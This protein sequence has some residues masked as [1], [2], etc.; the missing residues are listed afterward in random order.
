ML[1]KR[2][3]CGAL[4]EARPGQSSLS[5]GALRYRAWAQSWS[6]AALAVNDSSRTKLWEKTDSKPVNCILWWLWTGAV[7]LLYTT[8]IKQHTQRQ[9]SWGWPLP[10]QAW[11]R[12]PAKLLSGYFPLSPWPQDLPGSTLVGW[13]VEGLGPA[14]HFHFSILI[15]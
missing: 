2:K 8:K 6:S 10:A 12:L 1:L 13:V 7:T 9:L 14:C 11:H 3:H 5:A 4:G 15:F